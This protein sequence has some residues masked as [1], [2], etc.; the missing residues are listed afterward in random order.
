[1]FSA[2]ATLLI[3]KIPQD[4]LAPAQ[5]PP[6]FHQV[7]QTVTLGEQEERGDGAVLEKEDVLSSLRQLC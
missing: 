5:V 3:T 1:M 6:S 2:L 4:S 7:S